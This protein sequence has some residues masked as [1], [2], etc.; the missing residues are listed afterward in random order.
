MLCSM[1]K[2]I[3]NENNKIIFCKRNSAFLCVGP[4]FKLHSINITT[5]PE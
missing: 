4:F 3:N 2:K 1:D 5:D